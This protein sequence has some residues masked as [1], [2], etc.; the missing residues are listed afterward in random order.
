[1]DKCCTDDYIIHPFKEFPSGKIYISPHKRE[2]EP[3]SAVSPSGQLGVYNSPIGLYS[4]ETLAEMK[5]LQGRVGG[6]SA[7]GYVKSTCY[8]SLNSANGKL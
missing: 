6:V 8:H 1:M 4:P 7:L 3:E 2:F 5:L